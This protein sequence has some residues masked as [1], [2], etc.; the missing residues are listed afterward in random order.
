MSAEMDNAQEAK[1]QKTEDTEDGGFE[2]LDQDIQPA[3]ADAG[4]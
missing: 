3:A 4:Q 1:R 2:P